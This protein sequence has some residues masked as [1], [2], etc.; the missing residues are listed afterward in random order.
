MDLPET[1]GT[2]TAVS[3]SWNQTAY[4]ACPAGTPDSSHT[5]WVGIGGGASLLQAGTVL[6]RNSNNDG[7]DTKNGM[8]QPFYEAISSDSSKSIRLTALP[9]GDMLIYPG[10]KIRSIVNYNPSTHATT[11]SVYDSTTG[12][13]YSP[14]VMYLD[15]TFY[16]AKNATFIDERLRYGSQDS[17]LRQFN[18]GHVQWNDALA[19]PAGQTGYVPFGQR[20]STKINMVGND[21]NTL[22]TMTYGQGTFTDTW[23]A[24]GQLE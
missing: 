16:S 22:A 4:K 13:D 14:A 17:P 5:T 1:G 15:S 9:R 11:F 7:R 24:C 20:R 19:Q 6:F 3:G 12:D 10:D 23:V 18:A 2:Y 8:V 21:G